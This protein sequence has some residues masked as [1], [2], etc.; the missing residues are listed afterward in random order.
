VDE[1]SA[2]RPGRSLPPEKTRYPLYRM[3]GGTQGRSGHVRKIL[4][5]PGFY[6][7][8]V[9]PVASCYTNYLY[10][11]INKNCKS[12]KYVYHVTIIRVSHYNKNNIQIIVQTVQLNPLGVTLNILG[13]PRN[14]KMPNYV[15]FIK[16]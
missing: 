11:V 1:G 10:Y 15:N 16:R 7:R 2:S 13:T 4:S 14:H 6:Q 3:L 5:P 8:T 12:S 9:Q